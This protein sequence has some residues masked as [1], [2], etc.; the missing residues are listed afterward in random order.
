[1][2]YLALQASGHTA[3]PVLA[4]GVGAAVKLFCEA[5][6]LQIPS[7]NIYAAPISTL[8]CQLTVL[9]VEAVALSR[10]LPLRLHLGKDLFC[11]L[12][13]AL[14]S[15]GLGIGAYAAGLYLGVPFLLL[16]P[17]VLLLTVLCYGVLSLKRG[18]VGREDLAHLPFGERLCALLEKM[19]LFKGEGKTSLPCCHIKEKKKTNDDRGRK[20]EN[21]FGKEGI[22]CR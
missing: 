15:V 6:L 16:L 8:F 19:R 18:A 7:V 5:T 14:V 17:C 11:P 13:C 4:M 20:K 22:Y 2:Q 3:T 21:D 12:F 9:S 10:A 1:M